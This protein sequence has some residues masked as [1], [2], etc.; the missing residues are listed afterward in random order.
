[1]QRVHREQADLTRAIESFAPSVE[2]VYEGKSLEQLETE[3]NEKLAQV[4]RT[5]QA[6]REK[7]RANIAA[8]EAQKVETQGA[9]VEEIPEAPAESISGKGAKSEPLGSGKGGDPSGGQGS[10]CASGA[11]VQDQGS[12]GGVAHVGVDGIAGHG[13]KGRSRSPAR[14]GKQ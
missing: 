7:V 5:Y 1:M 11:G 2:V 6:A 8:K 10:Q 9:F 4:Q 12:G 13:E 14:K 3:R